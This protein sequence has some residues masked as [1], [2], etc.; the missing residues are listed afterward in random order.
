[1]DD[2]L[3]YEC[4]LYGMTYI[5]LKTKKLDKK[6]SVLGAYDDEENVIYIDSNHLANNPCKDCINTILHEFRHYYQKKAYDIIKEMKEKNI[7]YSNVPYYYDAEK[8]L[9]AHEN[10]SSAGGDYTYYSN[11]LEADSREYAE[12]ESKKYKKYFDDNGNKNENTQDDT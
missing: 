5:E 8:W 10:Y 2:L 11:E 6:D 9:E 7:D 12:K 3:K 1:M 4:D